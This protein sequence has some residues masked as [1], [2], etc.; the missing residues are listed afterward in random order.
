[1]S[2]ALETRPTDLGDGIVSHRNGLEIRADLPFNAWR[3]LVQ[4]LLATTDRAIWSLGDAWEYRTHFERDY[5][6]AIEELAASSRILPVAGRVARV[7]PFERRRG[8]LTFEL[9]EAVASLD[10]DEQD[11]WLDE[12]ER[13]G[14]SRQQLTFAFAEQMPRVPVAAISLRVVEDRY[15]RVLEAADRR[16]VDPKAWLIEAVDEKLARERALEAA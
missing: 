8:Q 5:H 1:M 9:H 7:F 11:A 3:E 2:T 10:P 15:A 12:V 16:D 13:Q 14:W 6:H 4:N